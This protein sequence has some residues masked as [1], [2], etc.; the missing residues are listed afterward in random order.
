MSASDPARWALECRDLG[1][2]CE[3]QVRATSPAELEAR[4]REH[5]KCAHPTADT[6]A[7]LSAR[8]ERARRAR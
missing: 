7:S 3:W 8:I 4:F 1:F 2:S 6:G 5:A